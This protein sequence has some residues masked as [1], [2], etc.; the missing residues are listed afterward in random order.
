VC[1]AAPNGTTPTAVT[2]AKDNVLAVVSTADLSPDRLDAIASAEYVALP[3]LG[4]SVRSSSGSGTAIIVFI[5]LALVGAAALVLIVG[6][7]R[8][9]RND[10]NSEPDLGAGAMWPIPGVALVDNSGLAPPSAGM[11]PDPSGSG[12]TRY[13]TG[14]DWGPEGPPT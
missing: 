1:G 8:R 2:F 10:H 11:Y 14:R 6:L 7:R 4:A 9:R 13:W 5:V 12:R 3:A